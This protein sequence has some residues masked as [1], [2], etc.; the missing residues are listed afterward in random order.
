MISRKERS[1]GPEITVDGDQLTPSCS[2]CIFYISNHCTH[3]TPTRHIP[4]FRK[5]PDWCEMLESTIRDAKEFIE[6]DSGKDKRGSK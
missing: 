6:R 5:T 2:R 1:F 4:D 3:V